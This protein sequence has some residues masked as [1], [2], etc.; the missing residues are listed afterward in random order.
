MQVSTTGMSAPTSKPEDLSCSTSSDTGMSFDN[1]NETEALKTL[2]RQL[3]EANA[4]AAGRNE[5]LEHANQHLR[6]LQCEVVMSH[7]EMQ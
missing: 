4:L 3:F 2:K 7:F 1:M 6:N 5:E